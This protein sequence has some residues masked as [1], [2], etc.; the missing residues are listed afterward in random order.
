[1]MKKLRIGVVGLGVISKFYLR[2][3]EESPSVRLTAVCDL[4]DEALAPHR[5]TVDC[6]RNH[7][8][9]LENTELDAI[10]VNVP[11][12]VHAEV[13]RDALL[14][15]LSVCVEKPLAIRVDD[16][17]EL[18]TLAGERGVTLFTAF[19][20]R[21]NDNILA[22]RDRLSS[23]AAIEALRVRYLEKIE[24]HIGRDGWY[25]APDRCGGGCVAD[26]GPNAYDVARLFLGDVEV[27]D[28]LVARDVN[29]MDRQALVTLAAPGG[30]VAEIELDWSYPYG[31][32]K[33]V[34]VKLVDGTV[35]GADMLAG[36]DGFKDSLWHEYAGIL[37][38]FENA[39]R[40]GEDQASDGLVTLELVADSYARERP[41]ESPAPAAMVKRDVDGLLVKVLKHARADRGMSLEPFASR[42]VRAGE[43]HELVTTDHRETA[44][45]ARIDRVGFLGFT[46]IKNAGVIDRGDEVRVNGELVGTVLGFDGC[47]FPNHYNILIATERPLTGPDLGLAPES[48]IHFS[49][50]D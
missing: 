19:H 40:A 31:E 33:D 9:L 15:G 35:D 23:G 29:G 25:L 21:Y 43:V 49:S 16:G 2:A 18:A 12:D 30:A 3:I 4:R 39:V 17:R 48:K 38:A 41:F 42:C 45:G 13:C 6:Y 1:M 27:R 47:H 28:A 34:E 10:V 14:T 20:R 8:E 11:N 37:A 44:A 5:A 7:W 22:L 24:E 46:E 26:N 36:H 32:R 50:A